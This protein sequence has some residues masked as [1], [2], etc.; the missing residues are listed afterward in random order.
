MKRSRALVVASLLAGVGVL[1]AC[2]GMNLTSEVQVPAKGT[3]VTQEIYAKFL[4]APKVGQKWTYAISDAFEPARKEMTLEV[5]RIDG[6][7]MTTSDA[8]VMEGRAEPITGTATSSISK[9]LHENNGITV[10]SEGAEDVTVPHK[11]YPGA[12]KFIGTENGMIIYTAWLVPGV[13]LVKLSS[14]Q[15]ESTRYT[16]ELKDFKQP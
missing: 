11:T 16:Q 5:T 14:G 1:T 15:T 2:P 6:D 7:V 3:V 12:A 10:T 8:T 4:P 13:G 9:P